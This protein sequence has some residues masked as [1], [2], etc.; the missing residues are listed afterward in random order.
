[1]SARPLAILLPT[2]SFPRH[3]HDAA[4]RF[5]LD[6]AV[7]LIARG[8]SIHVLA[9]EPAEDAVTAL[10]PIPG[11]TVEHVPYARPRALE[12]T[13]YEAGVLDNL[14]RSWAAWPGLA[15]F[16]VALA[17][18][19]R[20][21]RGRFDAVLSH[22]AVPC[23]AVVRSALGDIPHVAVWHSADCFVA[24]RVPGLARIAESWADQHLFVAAHWRELITSR[25]R[26]PAR[27]EVQ[28]LGVDV[29]DVVVE[30][31]RRGPLRLAMMSRL[32]PIKRVDLA[33]E[34]AARLGADA[35]LRIAGEGPEASSLRA[36]AR[37]RGV[38]VEWLG[39]VD[40][41]GKAELF[42]WAEIALAL[43]VATRRGREEGAPIG[44]AEAMARGTA[45]VATDVPAHR[46]LLAQGGGL[47]VPVTAIDTSAPDPGP[48]VAAVRRLGHDTA[49]L[50]E[51]R[52]A[53]HRSA[54]H[55]AHPR[56]AAAVE[57]RLRAARAR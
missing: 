22:F 4:G 2:T 41:R 37:R 46:A 53:A 52:A 12:R 36:L 16:P 29:P 42:D 44:P 54:H 57:E 43:S 32:V 11:L 24:S 14:R 45:L 20:P 3:P 5:V 35:T 39:A 25:W 7:S 48:V 8:H 1:M 17:A 23:A 51:T 30:K 49:L 40:A 15:S 56:V 50:A 47:L 21:H 34:A 26:E 28:S 31:P 10:P 19:M 9:P 33:I 6:L 55:R 13:F 38:A 27:A 18:R